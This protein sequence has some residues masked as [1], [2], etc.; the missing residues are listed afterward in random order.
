[1]P[2]Y[3]AGGPLF[4]GCLQPLFSILTATQYQETI[5]IHKLK[6]LHAIVMDPLIM[7]AVTVQFEFLFSNF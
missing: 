1:M 6:M 7:D 2:D 5:C 4:V 3:Q